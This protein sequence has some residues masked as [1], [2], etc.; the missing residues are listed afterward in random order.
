MP[1]KKCRRSQASTPRWC[2][3]RRA[4]CGT[5]PNGRSA[6]VELGALQR[7]RSGVGAPRSA[8][9]LVHRHVVLRCCS[10][11]QSGRRVG[12]RKVEVRRE[13]ILDATVVRCSRAASAA[14][15]WA[16][17]RRRSGSAPGWSST[18]SAPRTR[19]SRRRSSTP[20][21]A[22]WLASTRTVA[23]AATRSMRCAACCP[24]TPPPGTRP[25]GR[26]GST[27]GRGAAPPACARRAAQLDLRWKAHARSRDPGRG[28]R[29][30]FSCDDP[31]G[32]AWRLSPCSTGLP[33]QALVHRSL[34]S[35]SCADWVRGCRGGELGH[36]PAS[37]LV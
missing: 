14:P 20:P 4:A 23:R 30:R 16:T 22:T 12:R 15:G 8:V 32:A 27:P 5:R 13:E 35:A 37:Q 36:R 19:C 9:M 26:S 25:A 2:T 11:G 29:G 1:A 10:S 24:R 17:S 33:V 3:P 31:D 28:R 6:L 7:C 21:T 18:T 34:P